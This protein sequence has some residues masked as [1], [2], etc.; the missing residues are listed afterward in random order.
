[1]RVQI[2][3]RG[4]RVRVHGGPFPVDPSVEGRTGLVVRTDG[5]YGNRYAVQLDVETHLRT[6]VEEELERLS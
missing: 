1:M 4:T 6:F 3:P 5:A 2:F